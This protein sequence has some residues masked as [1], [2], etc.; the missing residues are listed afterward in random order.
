MHHGISVSYRTWLYH[1]PDIT[2][3]THRTSLY[4]TPNIIVSYTGCHCIIHRI[5]LY[6][7]L[8]RCLPLDWRWMFH[9]TRGRKR[10]G[11]FC[12]RRTTL[13]GVWY[14]DVWCMIQWCLVYDRVISGVWYG[15]VWCMIQWCLVHDRV[16]SGK[17]ND[18]GGMIQWGPYNTV[19]SG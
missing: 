18:V 7:T 15:D 16:L 1:A 13:S 17:H 3:S 4:H 6:H 12:R 11:R 8:D 10:D 14:N 2:V 9:G 19:R 5:S